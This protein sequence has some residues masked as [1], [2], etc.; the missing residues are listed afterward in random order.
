MHLS[1]NRYYLPTLLSG[2]YVL[3]RLI[4]HLWELNLCGI[5]KVKGYLP[6]VVQDHLEGGGGRGT[7]GQILKKKLQF[8]RK[9]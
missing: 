3:L 5:Y 6:R 8:Q 9:I 7:K 4:Q 1:T 2:L